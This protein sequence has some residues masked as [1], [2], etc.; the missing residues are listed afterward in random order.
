MEGVLLVA[1]SVAVLTGL[2]AL[3]E[4]IRPRRRG[5]GRKAGHLS[6]RG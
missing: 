3:V 4:A 5:V 1:G 2:A 6:T